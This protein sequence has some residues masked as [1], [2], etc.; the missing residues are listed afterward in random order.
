ME[1]WLSYCLDGC[2]AGEG[3]TGGG[4]NAERR[5]CIAGC[6]EQYPPNPSYY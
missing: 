4:T 2:P 1:D 3:W 6:F 5:E